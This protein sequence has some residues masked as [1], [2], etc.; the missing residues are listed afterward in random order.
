MT[1]YKKK[2]S[3]KNYFRILKNNFSKK[4]ILENFMLIEVSQCIDF[5]TFRNFI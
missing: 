3:S 1:F 4:F 5:K 2:L